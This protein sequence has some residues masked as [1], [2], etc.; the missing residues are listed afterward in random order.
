MTCRPSSQKISSQSDS[1]KCVTSVKGLLTDW[2]THGITGCIFCLH[3]AWNQNDAHANKKKQ[4]GFLDNIILILSINHHTIRLHY[5]TTP[6]I[7]IKEAVA[8][9][10]VLTRSRQ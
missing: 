9:K 2:I 4:S 1:D 7:I 5:I 8:F 10:F 6:T 3:V